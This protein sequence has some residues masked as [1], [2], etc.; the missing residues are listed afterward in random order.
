VDVERLLQ[1]L[2]LLRD[3]ATGE[4][5]VGVGMKS[6][7][8]LE[9]LLFSKYQMFRT[10]YWHHAVRAGTG[11]YKRIVETAVEAGLLSP[12]ELIGPTDE[13]LLYDLRRRAV[14]SRDPV[15][16]RLAGRWLPA[17][18][19]RRLPKRATEIPAW[20]LE[21]ST[22]PGWVSGDTAE[23]RRREDGIAAELGLE[24]GEVILDFPV[25]KAM[26][27]LDVLVDRADGVVRL[28]GEGIA[29][30]MDLPKLG[31]ELYRT[32]RVLRLFTFERR[33][34]D[35]DWLLERLAMTP[36]EVGNACA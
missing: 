33:E 35:P 26:F 7:S 23:K 32:A 30:L 29:G 36:A 3:P 25:K 11:L 27:Q 28:G 34:V 5:E 6:L 21:G 10:V 24:P 13:E 20:Q 4:W 16:A 22:V 9:S 19:E 15:A 17:L 14:A 2:V 31:R 1:G 12:E 8:T 18:R